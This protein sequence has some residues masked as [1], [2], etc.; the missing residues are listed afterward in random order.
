MKKLLVLIII[1]FGIAGC[2]FNS[3]RKED[4]TIPVNKKEPEKVVNIFESSKYYLDSNLERYIAYKESKDVDVEEAIKCVNANIDHEFYTDVSNTNVDDG[5]LMLVNKYT[6]LDN[7]YKPN[8]V[9]MDTKYSRADWTMEK[10]AYEHFKEMVDAAK[11]DNIKIYNTSS[12]RSYETQN[13]IYN[14]YVKNESVK[15]ADT[16]SARPGHSEHQTGFATD[17]NTSS[18]SFH[19]ENTKEYEWL[20][21]NS[22][23]YGFI[24]RYPQ[25]K[26]YITGYMFEPWHYRYIGIDAAKIVYENNITYEEYYAV[27]VK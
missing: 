12:Y 16:H 17:I 5:I 1:L 26:E 8:L 3:T 18:A 27:Y 23:K 15:E 9:K 10:E 6:K 20:L 13:R 19:F 21:N 22:Y 2:E 14:R 7:T 4:D 25:G 24:L 11:K